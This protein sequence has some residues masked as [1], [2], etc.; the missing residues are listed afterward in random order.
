M[1]RKEERSARHKRKV[2]DKDVEVVIANNTYGMFVYESKHGEISLFLDNFGD[3]EVVTYGELRKLKKYLE[4]MSLIIVEVIDDDVSIMDV[5]EG[6]RIQNVYRDYFEIIEDIEDQDM[7]TVDAISVEAVEDFVLE[8]NE[9]EFATAINIPA[10]SRTVIE[11]TVSLFKQH[12][13]NDYKKRK[14]VVEKRP[15]TARADF[16]SDIEASAD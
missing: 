1:S 4:N 11:T 6:L 16:W 9:R 5:A 13:L 10:L 12:M 8:S 7:Q 15:E 3:D 2:I 14:L